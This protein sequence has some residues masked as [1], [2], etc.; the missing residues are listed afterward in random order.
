MGASKPKPAGPS[1]LEGNL[2]PVAITAQAVATIGLT[3]TAVINIPQAFAVVG[4]L[5]VYALVVISSLKRP[6]QGRSKRHP[7][8]LW[9]AQSSSA[10]LMARWAARPTSQ[11]DATV[12]SKPTTRRAQ[13]AGSA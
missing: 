7:D 4:F 1:E 11:T 6:L 10:P 3:L 12:A 5:L 13:V 9:A 8:Q 2:G